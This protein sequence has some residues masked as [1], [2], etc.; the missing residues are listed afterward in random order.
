[1]EAGFV[2]G[3]ARIVVELLQDFVT[4]IS[5]NSLRELPPSSPSCRRVGVGASDQEEH[6]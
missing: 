2:D 3:R 4:D 6:P 5:G 1:V